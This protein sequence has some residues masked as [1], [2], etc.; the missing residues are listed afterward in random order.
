MTSL[1]RHKWFFGFACGVAML[2]TAALGQ[3]PVGG[4][5]D[6]GGNGPDK[7]KESRIIREQSIYIPYEKL[8]KV[9]EKQG[10]GVF[11]PYEQFQELWKAAREKTKPEGEAKPPVGAILAE[12]ENEATVAKEVVRVKAKVKIEVLAEGWHEVPLAL[13]DA[14]ITGA[15]IDG[16]PA[17]LVPDANQGYKLLL[18]K[19]G[20]EPQQV[21]LD[22]E[23]AKAITSAPGQNHVSFQ[24]PRAPVSRW[25][26][27]IPESGVKVK[28]HPMLAASEVPAEKKDTEKKD[29]EGG[30]EKSQP[31][32]TVILAFV[33]AS[34]TVRI[35]WTPK[36]EGATG[37]EALASVQTE[38]QVQVS[39]GLTRTQARLVYTIS[40]A[41]LPT[42]SIH[43]P[44]GQKVVNVFDAN[45][46]GWSVKTV[47]KQQEITVDLF[48]PAKGNQQVVVELEKFDESQD[49]M[50]V[51]V[52]VVAASGMGRQQGAVVVQVGQG[53]RAE[54]TKRTGLL[55]VDA[56]ELP[57]ALARGKW[58]FAYRF[59]T[60]PY[61]LALAVEKVQP[62]ILVDSLV[63]V[64]LRPERLA[65]DML[66]VYT[67]QRA[68]VFRLEMDVPEGYEVRSVT[69]RAVGGSQPVQVD[70]FDLTGPK[71]TRLVVNLGRKALGK[72]GLVVR[73]EC[74]LNEPDLLNPTGKAAKIPL[75]LPR[76]APGTVQHDVG[77]VVVYAPESLRVNPEGES[78]LRV[79][80]FDEA[81][82]DMSGR[83]HKDPTSRP[84]LAFAFT[85][86]P[87]KMTLAA[88]RRKPQVTVAQLLVGRVE[89]DA[90]KYEATFY[91]DVR[92]S[93]VKSL[94]I[95]VPKTL[96]DK[97]RNTTSGIRDQRLAP[98][99]DDVPKGY[100][101]WVF[102]GETELLGSGKIVLVWEDKIT[103]LGVGE[104]VPLSVPR[105]IPAKA[106][107]APVDREW[108]QIVLAKA[109]T[110]DL[111]PSDQGELEN[112]RPIDPQHDLIPGAQVKDA[113]QGY[114]FHDDWKL[115]IKAKR[116]KLE[117][118]KRTSV[119]RAVVQMVVTPAEQVGVRAV[120]RM[121]SAQQR[122]EI[123]LPKDAAFDFDPIRINGRAVTPEG[124]DT[125]SYFIPLTGA[126]PDDAFLLE[127]RY[128][129]PGNGD[130]LV[131]PKLGNKDDD[132]AVQK[133]FLCVYLPEQL[134]LLD[135]RGPW[136]DEIRWQFVEQ[137]NCWEPGVAPEHEPEK[138]LN[139]VA[140]VS[141]SKSR[142]AGLIR[143]DFNADGRCYVF[144]TLQPSGPLQ[145]AKV[146][147]NML[148]GL[149][150]GLL[151][152][153]GLLLLSTGLGG[154]IV[155]LGVLATVL[156]LSGVFWPIFAHQI[157]DGYL[158]AGV[159][160]VLILWTV[161]GLAHCRASLTCL[162]AK[163]P[164]AT[165]TTESPPEAAKSDTPSGE[166]AETSTEQPNAD[167]DTPQE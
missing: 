12:V 75:V 104:E 51:D 114:E 81:F 153:G 165:T 150:I 37:L 24:A 141:S 77:R 161:V 57:G 42:L 26:V 45:V 13:A 69:G 155:A 36:A 121:R 64:E 79:V 25:R 166:S 164:A 30:S 156:V 76:V 32:E 143:D 55:Q 120:Y 83:N 102:S 20:K 9:F 4:N 65:M 154:R 82:K 122:L 8:R 63:E 68:G 94:R 43:V 49:K 38:Q 163:K 158:A 35:E 125:G 56:R 160:I 113:A 66:A 54:A 23:Y 31:D 135:A 144:S 6:S 46:R 145:L 159:L 157:L 72:V 50:T 117:E 148:H 62:R 127:L 34:P 98:A 107:A 110:I 130:E 16:K 10:R 126:R 2:A 105:L 67:I 95:D 109:E 136:T 48:E 152:L 129:M 106:D 3:A 71:K 7:K 97:L 22:L 39:E 5:G 96:S 11:L 137:M 44:A 140:G 28:I 118:V 90:V 128:T 101:A 27:R 59:A 53:L 151:V 116:Y 86:E 85:A 33:G 84:I 149:V 132:P 139:W 92:F 103:K 18:E 133:V 167:G 21:V 88:E 119:E 60:V 112:L 162:V 15:T 111:Q 91:Y 87:T 29:G 17:R 40:R 58:D 89:D 147:E 70:T 80:S 108:G 73:L 124:G 100:D 19:K 123:R 74:D 142:A 131:L 99:P 78:G 146:N 1:I 52:P 14:A 61:E 93:G 134:A 138:L 47:N 41:K 115:D